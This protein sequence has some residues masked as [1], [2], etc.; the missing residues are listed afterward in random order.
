MANE[1]ATRETSDIPVA[2]A[3]ATTWSAAA[4]ILEGVGS[5]CDFAFRNTR[6]Q[7]YVGDLLLRQAD[8]VI[9]KLRAASDALAVHSPALEAFVRPATKADI[10]KHLSI[11]LNSIPNPGIG[12]AA[13]FGR[14]L[15]EDV[16]AATPSYG[17][18]DRACTVLRQTENFMPSIAKVLAQIETEEKALRR[19]SAMAHDLPK[20]VEDL[21]ERISEKRKW[22]AH[23]AEEEQ[24]RHVGQKTEIERRLGAGKNVDGFYPAD[25][26]QEVRAEMAGS[27][28]NPLN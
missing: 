13:V 7:H 6:L 10:R 1:M 16:G 23:R 28:P 2:T 3:A 15:A 27:S 8:E 25:L 19:W 17:A 20:Y 24:R 18:L 12:D 9:E 26:V 14:M 22:D 21:G 5:A 4:K 11:L